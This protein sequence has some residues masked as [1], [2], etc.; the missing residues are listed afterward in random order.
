[1]SSDAIL[2]VPPAARYRYVLGEPIAG[3]EVQQGTIQEMAVGDRR[4]D[5]S[6]RPPPRRAAPLFP[7]QR[8]ADMIKSKDDDD[9]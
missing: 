6:R 4:H 5:C 7:P 3:N 8:H 2:L 9:G 1:M